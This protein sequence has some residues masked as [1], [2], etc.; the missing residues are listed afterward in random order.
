MP[1]NEGPVAAPHRMTRAGSLVPISPKDASPGGWK[2]EVSPE[3]SRVAN[4]FRIDSP[5]LMAETFREAIKAMQHMARKEMRNHLAA[6]VY[7]NELPASVMNGK[8]S[9]EYYLEVMRR[10]RGTVFNAIKNDAPHAVAPRTWEGR[11]YLDMK[12]FA[13][14]NNYYARVLNFGHI[15]SP[16]YE[17]RPYFDRTVT[18]MKAYAGVLAAQ[19]TKNARIRLEGRMAVGVETVN[20]Y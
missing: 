12:D 1:V 7:F 13:S 14:F 20:V 10:R 17:A 15:S 3:F 5:I 2:I 19:A 11:T 9:R 4:R 18:T 6:L 8:I 16:H